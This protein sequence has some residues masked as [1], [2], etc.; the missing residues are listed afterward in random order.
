M[1]I[2]LQPQNRTRVSN[3]GCWL[4]HTSCSQPPTLN[5]LHEHTRAPPFDLPFI[6]KQAG[7]LS[8]CTSG[9]HP[10]P[11]M[12]SPFHSLTSVLLLPIPP[13]LHFCG[14]PLP[15][16]TTQGPEPELACPV[17]LFW[18]PQGAE[19]K[20]KH[21]KNNPPCAQLNLSYFECRY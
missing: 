15:H 12:L 10:S 4:P 20:V 1:R 19:P 6:L 17:G 21:S 18:V 9:C 14:F 7:H 16:P 3:R 11:W 2:C 13:H 5:K 8:P